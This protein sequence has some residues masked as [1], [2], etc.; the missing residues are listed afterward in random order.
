M[1]PER[2]RS[3]AWRLAPTTTCRS[4]SPPMCCWPGCGRTCVTAGPPADPTVWRPLAGCEELRNPGKGRLGRLAPAGIPPA[5]SLGT[6]LG[7]AREPPRAG[8]AC[9][10]DLAGR[11]Q[12]HGGY[13]HQPHQDLRRDTF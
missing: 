13:E 8:P 9:G 5:C 10:R 2:M 12:P 1:N 11:L 7:G 4:A 3:E 6:V